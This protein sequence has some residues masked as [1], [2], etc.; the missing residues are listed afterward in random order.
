MIFLPK[1]H[2][3]RQKNHPQDKIL[4]IQP[5]ESTKLALNSTEI[6]SLHLVV[7]RYDHWQI[8]VDTF[9]SDVGS[10]NIQLIRKLPRDE[11]IRLTFDQLPEHIERLSIKLTDL[12]RTLNTIWNQ[13]STRIYLTEIVRFDENTIESKLVDL[14]LYIYNSG[15][16]L[17][18]LLY[19]LIPTICSDNDEIFRNFVSTMN[20]FFCEWCKCV[21][22]KFRYTSIQ[23]TRTPKFKV[24]R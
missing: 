17:F 23:Q 2:Y 16:D 7:N 19:E 3:H 12:V 6:N 13:D 8:A 10:T 24:L 22:K 20:D 15:F 1:K 21:T 18:R 9:Q 4:L 11:D 5:S 14:V